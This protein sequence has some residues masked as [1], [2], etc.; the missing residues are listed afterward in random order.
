MIELSDLR[1]RWH[2]SEPLVIDIERLEVATGERILVKGPSGSGKTTLLNLLGGVALPEAGSI[3]IAG[4][5]LSTLGAAARDA[6][7][8]DR[9][10]FVFQLFNLVPYLSLIENVLLPCSFSAL[11]RERCRERDSNLEAEARRLLDHMELDVAALEKRPVAEL[12]VGQQ[13]RVAVARALIGAPALVIADEPTSALD[14]DTRRSFL[15]L[16]FGELAS[17]GATL[18]YVSHDGSIE[19][20]FDRSIAL[21]EINRAWS[22][23]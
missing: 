3:S 20:A 14:A 4:T 19:E 1:F 10:G 5:E 21:T 13:Q 18:V 12:S 9:I 6:F 17:V 15:D 7:R 22:R 11:R 23:S 2:R 8:A 16:L